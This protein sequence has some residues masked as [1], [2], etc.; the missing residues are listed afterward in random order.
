MINLLTTILFAR[1]LIVDLVK[2]VVVDVDGHVSLTKHFLKVSLVYAHTVTGIGPKS[3]HA[4]LKYLV[5][6]TGMF[7]ESFEGWINRW[8]SVFADI[9][10]FNN[11]ACLLFVYHFLAG[12]PTNKVI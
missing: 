6:T 10:L 9:Y 2:A 5:V 11:T 3:T 7:L 12:L 4:R 1:I 8:Q